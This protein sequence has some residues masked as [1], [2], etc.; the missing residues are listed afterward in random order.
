MIMLT[1]APVVVAEDDRDGLLWALA[2]IQQ[3]LNLPYH[4]AAR[5]RVARD[6]AALMEA[7]TALDVRNM[8][9]WLADCEDLYL[10]L[11]TVEVVEMVEVVEIT[12][13]I[14]FG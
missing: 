8:P 6:R 12:A 2:G 13:S 4:F 11:V 10:E 14:T 9:W 7:I 3:Q 1:T 5:S